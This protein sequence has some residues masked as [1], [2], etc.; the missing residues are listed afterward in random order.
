MLWATSDHWWFLLLVPL[1]WPNVLSFWCFHYRR[2]LRAIST[3]VSRYHKFWASV[4]WCLSR[5]TSSPNLRSVEASFFFFSEITWNSSKLAQKISERKNYM[6]SN[7]LI[8]LKV[9]YETFTCLLVGFFSVF[10]IFIL[11]LTSVVWR[12][13]FYDLESIR[14]SI[15]QIMNC[16]MTNGVLW[17][18]YLYLQGFEDKDVFVCESRYSNRHKSF[19]KIK[20][21]ILLSTMLYEYPFFHLNVPSAYFNNES[22]L[23]LFNLCVLDLI[24]K[25][26]TRS[27]KFE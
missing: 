22:F 12:A 7:A 21:S 13:F 6:K 2:C 23:S 26:Q 19:K 9:E 20:A 17:F 14:G 11:L 15:L 3:P 25:S 10:I 27:N 16:C 18:E 5:T 1:F 8:F 24:S 4:T